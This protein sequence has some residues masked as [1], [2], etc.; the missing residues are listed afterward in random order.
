MPQSARRLAGI[1]RNVLP[2]KLVQPKKALVFGSD[3]EYKNH[4]A[5]KER[6]TRKTEV[7]LKTAQGRQYLAQHFPKVYQQ[8]L[9]RKRNPEKAAE[10]EDSVII[11]K[12]LKQLSPH[13]HNQIMRK[14]IPQLPRIPS[15][16]VGK[17]KIY[18]PSFVIALKRNER[19]EPY[20][21]VF[22]VPLNFSKLDLRDYLFHLYGVEVLAIRSSVL[23]GKL[24]RK[25]RI[26]AGPGIQVRRGP[27]IRTRARKKMI[28]QLVKPFRFPRPLDKQELEEYAA[29]LPLFWVIPRC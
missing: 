6:W 2:K 24:Q 22:E 14:T 8:Y 7:L 4:V 25:Y 18:L 20:H 5:Q 27:M 28:V 1:I 21:A 9:E 13:V 3:A 26:R 16:P 23:P 10:P 29:S 15:F 19:L 17:R 11:R 12:K